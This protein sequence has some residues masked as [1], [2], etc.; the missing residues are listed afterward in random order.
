MI[1]S[2]EKAIYIQIYERLGDEIITGKYADNDHIPG[3]R[4][5]AALLE[6]NINTVIKSYNMLETRGMIYYKR[7]LGAFVTPGAAEM[8]KEERRREFLDKRLPELFSDMR[9]LGITID[10]VVKEWEQGDGK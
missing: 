5:Y 3:M 8:V 2:K 1:F 6:V 10:D 9:L 4:E 7:G